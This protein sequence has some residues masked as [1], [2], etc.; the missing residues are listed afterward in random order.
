M[1][2]REVNEL[3]QV[4]EL[5][6]ERAPI[7]PPGLDDVICA[8][9]TTACCCGKQGHSEVSDCSGQACSGLSHCLR[10]PTRRQGGMQPEEHLVLEEGRELVPDEITH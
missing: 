9:S 5:P 4:T 6:N 2:I 3:A 1:G 10:G 8:L 7:H